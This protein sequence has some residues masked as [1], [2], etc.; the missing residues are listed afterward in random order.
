MESVFQDDVVVSEVQL[1]PHD[2][3]RLQ[4][5]QQPGFTVFLRQKNVIDQNA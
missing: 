1:T 2:Q 4:W 3:I 5:Q